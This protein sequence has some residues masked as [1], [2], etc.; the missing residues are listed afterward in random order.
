[1]AF[2]MLSEDVIHEI[3]QLL[4]NNQD[5]RLDEA[6][7]LRTVCKGWRARIAVS[8]TLPGERLLDDRHGRVLQTEADAQT[9]AA[10]SPVWRWK[11]R[12]LGLVLAMASGKRCPVLHSLDLQGCQELSQAGATMQQIALAVVACAPALHTL[13][14]QDCTG[15]AN[16][17]GLATAPAL[18]TLDLGDCTGLSSVDDFVTLAVKLEHFIRP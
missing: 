11:A 6:L 15:L 4:G 10:L 14:L 2:A 9:A 8:D 17:D 18:H 1:M 16:V 13:N 5:L 12:G 7:Q 3:F